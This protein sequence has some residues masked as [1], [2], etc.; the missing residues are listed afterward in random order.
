VCIERDGRR[1]TQKGKAWNSDYE[2]QQKQ[3]KKKR[4]EKNKPE[5]GGDQCAP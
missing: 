2:A 5:A 3:A 1:L 4:E